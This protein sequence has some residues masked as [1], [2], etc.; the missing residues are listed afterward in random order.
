MISSQPAKERLR[1]QVYE[2]QLRLEQG[3]LG[4][5]EAAK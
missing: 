1:F 3:T 4:A 5:W 2:G